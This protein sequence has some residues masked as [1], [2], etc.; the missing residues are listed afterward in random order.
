VTGTQSPGQADS[1]LDRVRAAAKRDRT[2]RLSNLMHHLDVDLL[3]R[4]YE[5]LNRKAAR[6]VDGLSWEDYGQELDARLQD[7]HSRIH[8]GRYRPQPV[9]RVWIPKADGRQRPLGVTSTEDKLVQQALVYLLNPIYETDFKGFSYGFR[10][11]RSQHDALDALHVAITQR[12]VSWILDTD[13]SAFFDSVDH[14]WLL[15]FVA[16]RVADRRVLRLIEQT[17][18]AGVVEGEQWH[19][20]KTGTPQG[21]VLS[22]LLANIYLHYSLDLWVDAWRKR[23][24]R[25]DV[26]VVRYADDAVL[27]FQYR[28]DANRFRRAL[29]ERLAKFSLKLHPEKTRLVEFGR[30]AETNRAKRKEGKPET[31]AFLG[32]THICGRRRSDGGFTV[33]RTTMSKRLRGFVS[34]LKDWLRTNRHIPVAAQGQLVRQALQGFANYFGVPGNIGALNAARTQ[35]CRA[36]FRAL[37]RRSQKAVRLNWQKMQHVIRQW[38]PSMRIVH[39]HPNERLR[40]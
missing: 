15:K 30:Y 39:P 13:I 31:F 29:T 24:A 5:A 37:R 11:G 26:Y 40:V 16:H 14:G 12:K 27:G 32:F 8:S 7:L 35:V 28:D 38:V 6:G 2:L 9:R 34:T 3:R 18:T 4:A 17:L 20:T 21:G 23:Y 36:W 33:H 1:G 22:P 19:P 10:P 25:G